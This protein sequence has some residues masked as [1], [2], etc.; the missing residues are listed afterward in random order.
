M[1]EKHR[2]MIE[3]PADIVLVDTSGERWLPYENSVIRVTCDTCE[4]QILRG[5]R[6]AHRPWF[7]C[8]GCVEL[9]NPWEGR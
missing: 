8:T 3:K 2:L 4:T 5:F 7:L 6:H 9:V 1:S